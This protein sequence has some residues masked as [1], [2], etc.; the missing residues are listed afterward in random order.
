MKSIRVLILLFSFLFSCESNEPV[1]EVNTTEDPL[2]EENS[3]ADDPDDDS[4]DDPGEEAP[5]NPVPEITLENAFPNLGFSRPLDLQSPND[6]TNR[7]F[8]VEQGGTVKVFDN[9]ATASS[10]E[11]FLDISGRTVSGGEL[12]LLGLAFH[13]DYGENGLFYVYYTP[14]NDVSVVSRFQVSSFDSN[15]ADSDSEKILLRIP[16]PFTNHNGGQLAFGTDGYLYISSGDGG[17][18][19]DPQGNAQNLNN[20]LGKILRI[21]VDIIDPGLEYGIPVDNPFLGQGNARAEIYAYGLRNPWRMSFDTQ[22]GNLWA[23]DVGQN[24]LEEIDIIV[25][26]ENYGW[27]IFEGTDCFSGDCDLAGLTPPV[28]EYNHDSGDQ[29]I[30][31]GY[32]YRGSTVNSLEGHYIYGDFLSGR[33]WSLNADSPQGSNSL[34]VES[35]LNISSFGTD[36]NNEIYVCGFD[37]KVYKFVEN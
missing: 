3:D 4:D 6:G 32:V 9:Q 30:T 31:G 35:G 27:K 2:T 28:F 12:G 10:S 18:G 20:L 36:A 16:Q 11:T 14:N 37:G 19:G 23:G 7:I 8:V 26:G 33:I 29:S 22:T 34:L 1:V 25:S 13:P 5:D 15:E 17:S 24:K 21:D